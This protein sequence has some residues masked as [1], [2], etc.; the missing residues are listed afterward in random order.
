MTVNFTF[1]GSLE[2]RRLV[3]YIPQSGDGKIEGH[4]GVTVATGVDLGQDHHG[5]YIDGHLTDAALRAKLD[6]YMGFI[7]QDA[8]DYLTLHPLIL[9]EAEVN[10]LDAAVQGG[11]VKMLA[12]RFDAVA[13][14]AD[15]PL[16]AALPERAQTAIASVAFQYG[17]LETKCPK[18]WLA[19][20]GQDW[21]A[22][23]DELEHFGDR[24]PSR[25][26]KEADLL[27]PLIAKA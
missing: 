21:A 27:R 26:G 9:T 22:A 11:Q 17:D 1:I 20:C 7:G 15:L 8:A 18:F 4:S 10:T 23:V 12:D 3:G 6:P 13:R 24:Y 14:Q 19:A 2:G 16:F 25:R 5:G